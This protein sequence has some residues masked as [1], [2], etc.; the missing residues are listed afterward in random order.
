[1]SAAPRRDFL[2][3]IGTEELPPRALRELELSLSTQFQAGL[4][5]AGLS[6]GSVESFATPRRLALL[7]RRLVDRQPDQ[8]IRRRGPPV[9]AAFDASGAPTRAATAFAQSCGVEVSA[10]GQVDEPKGRFL[11]FA[12]TREGARTADL[13]PAIAQRALEA[14]PIPKRMRWGSGAAEFVRPVHWLVMSYGGD[15]IDAEI[16]GVHAGLLTRGHRFLAPKPLRISTPASYAAR[17]LE[18]GF[19]VA[20]FKA[21]R[22]RVREQA[23]AVANEAGGDALIEEDL[24]DEVTALVEWPV[25]LVG[26]FDERFLALPRE[27]LIS[28]LQHHQRYFPV[29]DAHG[30]LLARFIAVANL[31]SRDPSKVREGNERVVKP[32]LSDAAFFYEQDR[33]R[34][35]ESRCAQLAQVTYQASLGSVGQKSARVAQLAEK[36]APD[37]GASAPLA[38]RGAELS[39]CDLVTQMV[40]EFPELQGIMGR[41]Y[42]L[43]DGEPPEVAEAI[44]EHYLPRGAGD[45]VP[46]TP[47]GIAVALA[48]KLDTLA[49]IFAIGQRPSGTRDPFGLRR[50]AIGILRIALERR[51]DFDLRALIGNA[52]AAQPVQAPEAAEVL[53]QYIMERLRSLYLE[54]PATES[55]PF[56]PT[57]EMFDA[58]L[59]GGPSSILD[60]DARLRAL[61]AF[62][63]LPEAASLTAANKRV[64]NILRRS[65][66]HVGES[67]TPDRLQE[68]AEIRLHDEILAIEAPVAGAVAHRGYTAAFGHLAQLRAAVDAFFDHVMVMD[69]DPVLRANRLALLNRLSRLFGGIA[70]LSRLPG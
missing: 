3:E 55:E 37:V 38:R 10:L 22:D 30:R 35:L 50:A 31:P 61:G 67:I 14:L 21:R 62:L 56:Q 5:E 11:S 12:G 52:V 2:F 32:R 53:Y 51:I 63:Q 48:D 25:A 23:I 4:K 49:G 18:R 57:T 39:K 1:M 47:C 44:R 17:L 16:L 19:V 54:R 24:L 34:T 42:A 45:E 20:D 8:E 69:E 60:F 26:S 65:A 41:Y 46:A 70:D 43:A 13:I 29:Q 15:V 9:S 66:T 58:V 68:P 28:T 40:G 7:V 36:I 64:A 6:H 33:K 27:A 59:A